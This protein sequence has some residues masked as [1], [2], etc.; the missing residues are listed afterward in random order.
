MAS[1]DNNQVLYLIVFLSYVL[2]IILRCGRRNGYWIC[3][4]GAAEAERQ[5]RQRNA[6]AVAVFMQQNGNGRRSSSRSSSSLAYNQSPE[7]RRDFIL[8][9]IVVDKAKNVPHLSKSED[10]KGFT[11]LSTKSSGSYNSNESADDGSNE[12]N[13]NSTKDNQHTTTEENIQ[14]NSGNNNTDLGSG[15]DEE[16]Q[17]QIEQ[18]SH[19]EK[20]QS[21]SESSDNSNSNNNNNKKREK[22]NAPFLSIFTQ[23]IKDSM[24]KESPPSSRS[25][26]SGNENSS[27][28]DNVCPICITEFEKDDDICISKNLEC[29]HIFHMECMME[30]LMRHDECPLCRQDYLKDS[31][32]LIDD[33]DGNNT[34]GGGDGATNNGRTS[35]RFHPR[36]ER[37][38]SF[39]FNRSH[40]V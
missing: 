29:P 26:N 32:Y 20:I 31:D 28:S 7:Q 11:L 24:L 36:L 39:R 17:R 19:D 33:N 22:S 4:R 6:D 16:D 1:L 21:D 18:N 5:R 12:S 23:L 38:A 25:V 2:Y 14:S 30:W 35:T 27:N 34:D 8:S 3:N 15:G 9:C 13:E 37:D 40:S 10:E